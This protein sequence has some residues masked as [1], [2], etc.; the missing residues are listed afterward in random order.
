MAIPADA[1]YRD[2]ALEIAGKPRI[3]RRIAAPRD[4]TAQVAP[5]ILINERLSGGD[6]ISRAIVISI[7]LSFGCD[8]AITRSAQRRNRSLDRLIVIALLGW[9]HT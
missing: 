7:R 9:Q 5:P 8:G 1:V 3:R 4:N 2:R 6:S